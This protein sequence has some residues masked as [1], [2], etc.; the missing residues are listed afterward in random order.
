MTIPELASSPSMRTAISQLLQNKTLVVLLDAIDKEIL[1]ELTAKTEPV[2][3]VHYDT[4]VSAK[5]HRL[6]GKAW[7][8]ALIRSFGDEK[9]KI[10]DSSE[11]QEQPYQHAVPQSFIPSELTGKK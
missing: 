10:E 4:T 7:T 8:L 9:A 6:S 11:A 5:N 3:G 1:K 2:I